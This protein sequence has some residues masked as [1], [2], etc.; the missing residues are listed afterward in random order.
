MG[1]DIV[2]QGFR[3][4]VHDSP[5]HTHDEQGHDHD[6]TS[7]RQRKNAPHQRMA[8]RKQCRAESNFRPAFPWQMREQILSPVKFLHGGINN[9]KDD[10]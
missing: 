4:Q 5:Q 6:S 8:R 7:E 1:D 10:S 2:P 3:F 9:D